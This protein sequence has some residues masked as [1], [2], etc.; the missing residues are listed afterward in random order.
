VKLSIRSKFITSAEAKEDYMTRVEE[1]EIRD[2]RIEYEII[3]DAYG[4]E[5]L[6][7]GWYCYL[8]DKISTPLKAKCIA[9]RTISPLEEGEEVEVLGMTSEDECEHEMFVMVKWHGRQLG[10]PLA[11]IAVVEADEATR[12][13]VED[14]HY[15][16]NRG[17]EF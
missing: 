14:W 15:W 16:V 5:E 7:M 11:Q 17:C 6:A 8:D 3:V 13:A 1:D 4:P 10:V 2:Q 12:E 9:K